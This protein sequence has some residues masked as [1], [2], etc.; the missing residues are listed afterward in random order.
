[1]AADSG[2]DGGFSSPGDGGAGGLGSG[3]TMPS[4]G[5]NATIR[6]A[7]PALAGGDFGG[8]DATLGVEDAR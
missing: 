7:P 4:S 8:L 5:K 6:P 2:S 3:V 1:M